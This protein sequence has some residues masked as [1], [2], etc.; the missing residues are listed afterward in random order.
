MKI[1]D[2][3]LMMILFLATSGALLADDFSNDRLWITTPPF[4]IPQV[5]PILSP[6]EV[7]CLAKNIYF[8][9]GYE[10]EEGMI[11]VAQVTKNRVEHPAYP[12]TYC[13]VV[14]QVTKNKKTG[15]R[16]AQFSWTLDG[17]P[18]VPY[19]KDIYSESLLIAEKILQNR[20]NSDIIPEDVYHYHAV[21]VKPKWA[22]RMQRVAKI[23]NHLFY[24]D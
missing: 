12:Q 10:P 21:Y 15:K 8:E 23:G 3:I 7:E 16:V 13:D 5:D 22:A 19:N 2:S 4:E 1:L 24:R 20:L 6:E 11:A 14:W 9:A 18:D 17:K